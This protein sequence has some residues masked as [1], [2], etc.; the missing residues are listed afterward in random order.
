[1][2]LSRSSFSTRLI[3]TIT[4][5]PGSKGWTCI[6]TLEPSILSTRICYLEQH[7]TNCYRTGRCLVRCRLGTRCHLS[8]LSRSQATTR[9]LLNKSSGQHHPYRFAATEGQSGDQ[10]H[11]ALSAPD[12]F[13]SA[14]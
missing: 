12:C 4:R 8:P 1:M 9:E 2:R 7:T 13:C 14:D 11:K 10:L 3:H 6:T 5:K